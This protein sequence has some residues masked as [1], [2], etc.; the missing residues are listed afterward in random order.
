M[1]IIQNVSPSGECLVMIIF[2]FTL[3]HECVKQTT[4]VSFIF[5]FFCLSKWL[6]NSRQVATGGGSLFQTHV[7]PQASAIHALGLDLHLTLLSL[8]PRCSPSPQLQRFHSVQFDPDYMS[9]DWP[10]AV[11]PVVI[12][13]ATNLPVQFG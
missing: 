9:P 7:L 11:C 5:L 2:R 1:A 8:H 10:M 12:C 4:R 3:V 13:R 6:H